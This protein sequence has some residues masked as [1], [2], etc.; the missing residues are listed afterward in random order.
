MWLKP[1]HA[2]D[3]AVRQKIFAE[4][5]KGYAVITDRPGCFFV[6]DW[7]DMYPDAQLFDMEGLGYDFTIAGP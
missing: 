3:K 4:I 5:V 6:G 2:Q 7:L 1:M